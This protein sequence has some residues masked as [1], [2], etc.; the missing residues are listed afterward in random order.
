[1]LIGISGNITNPA[2]F[3]V[4]GAMQLYSRD[5]GVSQHI[6]GHVAFVEITQDSHQKLTFFFLHLLCAQQV[7]QR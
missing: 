4:K 2:A 3:N 6:E 7:A 1:M 5:H